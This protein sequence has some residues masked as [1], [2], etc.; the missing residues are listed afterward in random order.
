M[1]RSVVL[2][3]VATCLGGEP[4]AA[5]PACA[6][7][8]LPG[9]VTS[10]TA[11]TGSHAFTRDLDGGG[12]VDWTAVGLSAGV[13][14][15][16]DPDFSAGMSLRYAEEDWHFGGSGPWRGAAPWEQLQ[17]PSV[18][19]ST[20]LGLWRSLRVGVSPTL[21]WAYDS[22]A[23]ASDA[24]IYGGVVSVA[25]V[26]TP[27]FTLG[28]GA[29]VT[30]QFYNVK[31]SPF[32][33]VDWRLT[34]RLRL[35]NAVPAGPEGAAGVELRF[36]AT[37]DWEIAAGGV[38]RSDRFRLTARGAGKGDVGETSGIPL[39]A[40]VSRRFPSKS[41]LD[42]YAGVMANGKLTI[43]DAD[44]NARVKETCDTAPALAATLSREF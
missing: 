44:G 20:S 19:L 14:K 2:L 18:A 40:R 16:F 5:S 13:S 21:E 29:G 26:F 1:F 35:A 11:A 43:R 32:V 36:A 37:P 27:R 8:D 34:D 30:R 31:T 3:V 10:S 17:R 33:I 39:L 7:G 28:G 38:S 25:M 15:Q 41:R 9:T 24:L 12:D 6:Q 42:V 22:K 4:L 23:D